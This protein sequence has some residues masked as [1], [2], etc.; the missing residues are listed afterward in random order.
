MMSENKREELKRK[1]YNALSDLV[2]EFEDSEGVTV[3]EE[4][5]EEA[6]EWF[7]IHHY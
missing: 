2:E 7:M 1:V 3:K 4:D 5:L 6:I